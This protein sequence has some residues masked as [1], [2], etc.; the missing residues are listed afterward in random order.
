MTATVP[1]S[2]CKAGRQCGIIPSGRQGC[3]IRTPHILAGGAATAGAI[4]PVLPV[5]NMTRTVLGERAVGKR[6]LKREMIK[7]AEKGASSAVG[8]TRQEYRRF[9]F[10]W[11]G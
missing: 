5:L 10:P 6:C 9:A 8:R 1:S 2:L 11:S 3:P 7:G 4:N